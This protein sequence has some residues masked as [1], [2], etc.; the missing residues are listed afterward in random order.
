MNGNRNKG[1]DAGPTFC[2]LSLDEQISASIGSIAAN[3]GDCS[4]YM[5]IAFEK[6]VISIQLSLIAALYLTL[7]QAT[8]QTIK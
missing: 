1:G 6:N 8:G 7:L 5:R 4:H 3:D 2:D